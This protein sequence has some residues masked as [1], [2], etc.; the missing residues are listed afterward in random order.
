MGPACK[1]T[2]SVEDKIIAELE[3]LPDKP[4]RIFTEF[5]DEMIRKYYVSKGAQALSNVLKK[6]YH[7]VKGRAERLGIKRR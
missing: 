1:Q 4:Y 3:S 6:T 7:Q 2:K 5:E